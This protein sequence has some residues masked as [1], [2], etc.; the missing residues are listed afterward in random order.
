MAGWGTGVKVRAVPRDK[1]KKRDYKKR[2]DVR[3]TKW[4]P[5]TIDD[6]I[7]SIKEACWHNDYGKCHF[8]ACDVSECHVICPSWICFHEGYLKMLKLK[9]PKKFP[10]MDFYD[11]WLQNHYV[12]TIYQII[13]E[14]QVQM[15]LRDDYVQAED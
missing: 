5:K 6:D 11:L 10:P 9:K 4:T 13:D 8:L 14:G 3:E 7:I 2:R 15:R 1:R 12:Q